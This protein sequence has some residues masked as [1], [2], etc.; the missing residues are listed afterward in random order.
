MTE[1]QQADIYPTEGPDAALA[2][3]IADVLELAGLFRQAAQDIAGQAGQ[4]QTSWYALSVF[5]DGPWTVSQAAR[6]LGT[7]RQAL[8]RTTNELLST[9]LATAEPNPDH[10]TAPLIKLTP[11]G[12]QV[13]ARIS[14]AATTARREWFADVDAPALEGAHAEIQRLRDVLR[15]VTS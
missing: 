13:L 15:D 1:R 2:A 11:D 14:Q 6:R 3:F 4:T 5:S 7:T 9:G 8:Q 10:Q 12:E